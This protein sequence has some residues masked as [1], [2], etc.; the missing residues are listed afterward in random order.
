MN[1]EINKS[2]L[3]KKIG[4]SRPTLNKLIKEYDNK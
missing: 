3:A 1:R 2:Q 4:A